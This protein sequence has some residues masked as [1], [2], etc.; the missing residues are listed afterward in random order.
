VAASI[1]APATTGAGAL[2]LLGA[3]GGGLWR[4]CRRSR[5]VR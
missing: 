4:R 3:I 1:A 5:P 2:L